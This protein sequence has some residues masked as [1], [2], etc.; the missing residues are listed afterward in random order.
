MTHTSRLSFTP[1]TLILFPIT[2]SLALTQASATVAEAKDARQLWYDSPAATW[3][4]A[5]PVGN[6]RLGAMDF[7]GVASAKLSL[8]EDSLWTGGPHNYVHHGASEHLET[9]RQLLFE[10]KQ[11]EAEQL[12]ARVFMSE[13]LRQMAY[14]PLGDL[15]LQFAHSE[16]AEAYRRQLDLD[17]AVV[18]T[19]YR[20]QDATYRREVFASYPDQAIVVHLTCSVDKQ[21][22]FAATL[23]SPLTD[24]EQRKADAAALVLTGRVRDTV[25]RTGATIKGASR[26][27]VHVRVLETDGEVVV[28]DQHI[29][30][31]AATHATLAITAATSVVSFRDVSADAVARSMNAQEHLKSKSYGRLLSHHLDDYQKLFHRVTIALHADGDQVDGELVDGELAG[32][33]ALPTDRRVLRAA[34]TEDPDLAALFFQYGRY[35]MIASSRAGSQPANLQGIWN[36]QIEPAWDS[37]YTTNINCEMNYWIAETC[38]LAECAEPLFAAMDELVESGRETAK[39]HYNARGWVLHH[40]FDR[41]RGT[42]P[43][44][45]ANHGIWVTGGAWLCQHLWWHYEFGGDKEFLRK[46][47]YPMM[48]G[49]CEFFQDYLVEDPRTPRRH[50]ISGPSNSPEQGGLVMGPTMDHQIIRDLFANTIS[51]ATEL[52]VDAEFREQLAAAAK[53]IAPNRIGQYGQLQE[54]LEDKDD[55]KNQHRHVSH[56]WGVFP[57]GEISVDSPELLAAARKSLE[58]RGDGGTG[59]SRAW[60]INLWARMRD[61]DRAHSVLNGLLTLTGSKLTDYRGGGVYPNLFDAHPPFQIDGN[62]GGTS[63]ICEMLVQSHRRTEDG[64][65]VVELLPAVPDA[66]P[67]GRI[68][69]IRVRGGCEIGWRWKRGRVEQYEL[70]N[71]KAEQCTLRVEFPGYHNTVTVPPARSIQWQAREL[72]VSSE[73]E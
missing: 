13:P 32:A 7:G 34:T 45:A 30:V 20:I 1:W 27:A 14:Q 29:R 10:G 51:A 33:R 18:S 47:A 48:K 25:S 68:T 21:L 8:N 6:G 16:D 58:L 3:V 24:C 4:E 39:V 43:I 28:D 67:S 19:S 40:N 15:Q 2:I 50:L 54:W 69:G 72:A 36:D 70:S 23:S 37:K 31:D 62:F 22:S 60:K 64:I 59:W 17:T 42:A 35:L 63:G 56:L 9:I 53:R 71:R 73:A 66:W 38:N 46:Q 65:P 44:N 5:L 61:G 57:G 11:Q 41:W 12:A 55:P 26:F 49:A 52:E